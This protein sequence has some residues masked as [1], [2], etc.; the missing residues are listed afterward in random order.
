MDVFPIRVSGNDKR[1]FA[2]GE[3]HCQLVAHLVGF[4]GGNFPGPKGLANL[5]SNHI[6]FLFASGHKLIL[7]FG[8][9]EFL[10]YR[11]GTA[12]IAAD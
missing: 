11:Q 12:L 5:V 6:I 9:H 7:P 4:F 2:L 1:I 3:A 10:I 8:Q